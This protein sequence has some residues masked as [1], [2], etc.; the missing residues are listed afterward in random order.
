MCA[1]KEA[2]KSTFCVV[3]CYHTHQKN[4]K[5]ERKKFSEG[6]E[7]EGEGGEAEGL[8][9]QNDKPLGNIGEGADGAKQS[10]CSI[11][12]CQFATFLYL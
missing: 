10:C 2:I 8:P 7:E 3:W 12:Q 6:E 1:L 11:A 5:C 9:T 4:K